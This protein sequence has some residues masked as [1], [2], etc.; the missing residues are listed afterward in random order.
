MATVLLFAA[1][2]LAGLLVTLL[3]ASVAIFGALAIA[4]GDPAAALA[5]GNKPNP[6]TLAAIRAEYHLDDPFW[7]QYW[8]WL[9][10]LVSGDLGRSIVF[11]T[12]VSALLEGRFVNT[13]MLVTYAAVLILVVGIGLGVLAGLR[14][15]RVNTAVTVG[16]TVA[17]GLPTFVMAVVLIWVFA[18]K[19]SWFP[20]YGS[21]SGFTDKLRHLTLPAVA[22][23][24]V[25]IAY[26]ARITRT[27]V[28]AELHSEHVDTA[29]A[30][31]LPWGATVRHHVL[32]NASGPI[33]TV[34]GL[35]VA[36]LVAGAAVAEQAFGINGLG[37][38]LIQSA[39][40]K[41]LA[42]VQ[43]LAMIMVTAFVVINTVV[44]I[45]NV[46]LDPRLANASR[47]GQ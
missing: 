23:S 12:D 45:V 47:G 6:A 25:F 29:R 33:L 27:S 44:D 3:V 1:R 26:V 2:R 17:M 46:V 15:R 40:R 14:G 10:G 43:V 22:L 21:G 7:S 30:R 20:I 37:S 41:D 13:F 24:F 28:S 34:S 16:T 19:L 4:P 36:G 35:T 32:R 8:H 11:R 38:L 31:G 9:S 5:G 39:S 42:V 18:T